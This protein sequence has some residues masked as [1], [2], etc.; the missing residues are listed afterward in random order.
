MD[1]P[2]PMS[3]FLAIPSAKTVHGVTP[4]WEITNILSPK[5]N[6]NKPKHSKKKVSNFGVILSGLCE[7][8]VVLGTEVIKK[9]FE[10]SFKFDF[11]NLP[12]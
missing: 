9:I 6:R 12:I 7:L 4:F 2:T 3:N 1:K 10:I 5:P 11:N 8:Q